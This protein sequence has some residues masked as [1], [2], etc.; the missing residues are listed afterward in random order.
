MGNGRS[1]VL[2]SSTSESEGGELMEGGAAVGRQQSP[3]QARPPSSPRLLTTPLCSCPGAA[4]FQL[5][6]EGPQD[7]APKTLQ[8]PPTKKPGEYPADGAD[9]T[10]SR[11][12]TLHKQ[13]PALPPKP[14]SRLPNHLTGTPPSGS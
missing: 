2:G 10:L 9:S 6:P 3:P 4:E 13:P 5:M 1:L 14:F 8:T 12:P 11:P 7:S